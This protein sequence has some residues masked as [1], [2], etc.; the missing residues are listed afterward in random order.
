MKKIVVQISGTYEGEIAKQIAAAAYRI[1]ES[2]S[3]IDGIVQSE[4]LV[5]AKRDIEIPAFMKAGRA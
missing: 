4:T 5:Q 3:Y 2:N 1:L